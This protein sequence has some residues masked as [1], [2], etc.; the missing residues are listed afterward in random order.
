M[1]K[2]TVKLTA[3]LAGNN[4]HISTIKGLE[5]Y[6]ILEAISEFCPQTGKQEIVASLHQAFWKDD[7]IVWFDGHQ[8]G[9]EV[10]EISELKSRKSTQKSK[11][12]YE[13]NEK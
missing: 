13:K 4:I 7:E 3:F 5:F 6:E 1:R 8:F 10:A 9:V 12:A 11:Y 2:V